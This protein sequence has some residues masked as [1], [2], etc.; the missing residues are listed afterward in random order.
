MGLKELRTKVGFALARTSESLLGVCVGVGEKQGV[1][2]SENSTRVG[3]PPIF[4]TIFLALHMEL[5][6]SE[7]IKYFVQ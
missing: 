1:S 5:D 2:E 4:I 7:I 3:T 6:G